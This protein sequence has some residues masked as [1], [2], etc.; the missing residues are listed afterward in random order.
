MSRWTYFATVGEMTDEQ[1]S[2]LSSKITALAADY[3]IERVEMRRL[4][5]V[6]GKPFGGPPQVVKPAKPT[7][8]E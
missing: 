2:A 6:S 3:P 1:A 8:S 7:Y 5:D 4:D